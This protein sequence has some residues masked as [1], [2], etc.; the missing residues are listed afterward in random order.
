MV[1]DYPRFLIPSLHCRSRS[2]IFYAPS[3]EVK[4]D[5]VDDINNSIQGTHAEES[6]I[7]EG[8]EKSDVSPP[9]HLSPFP[10]L[11]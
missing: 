6:H 10:S 1:L 4:Q 8:R 7:K 5:W 2:F 11:I 9:R 3:R